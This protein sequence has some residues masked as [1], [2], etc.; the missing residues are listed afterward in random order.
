MI[1]FYDKVGEKIGW[2]FSK[3][4][5]NL[6]I[7]DKKWVFLEIIKSYLKEDYFVLDLGS[8]GGEKTL[9]LADHCKKIV[10]IDSSSGMINKSIENLN[11][12]RK[13][14]VEFFQADINNLN[15]PEKSFDLV[16]CRHSPFNTKEIS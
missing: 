3:I 8:G 9:K 6:S 2:N 10:G 13:K 4:E 16:I 7:E 15:F 5:K 14:N 12:T 1:S 11:K